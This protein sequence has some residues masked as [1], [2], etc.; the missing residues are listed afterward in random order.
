MQ[1]LISIFKGPFS[2][3]QLLTSFWME[4]RKE[5]TTH[6]T[7]K[8]LQISEWVD[9]TKNEGL[10]IRAES[11]E[12]VDA[13]AAAVS[14]S[15]AVNSGP[16]AKYSGEKDAC[17]LKSDIRKKAQSW[18][19]HRKPHVHCEVSYF[20]LLIICSC[21]TYAWLSQITITTVDM[22]KKS[23]FLGQKLGF[24]IASSWWC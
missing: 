3:T 7:E 10:K 24:R 20:P 4:K 16:N 22:A 23:F 8:A 21:L 9:A 19:L 17:F 12:H 18:I 5:S 2:L 13:L 15:T 6:A 11:A 1:W 14:L